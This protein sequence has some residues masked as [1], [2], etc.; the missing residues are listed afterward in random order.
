[1]TQSQTIIF[2][3]S[4]SNQLQSLRRSLRDQRQWRL[5]FAE[6]ADAALAIMRDEPVDIL[7]SETRLDGTK[8]TSLLK[9]AQADHPLTTRLL[10][11]GQALREPA[12]EMVHHAHQFIAKP[13]DKETLVSTL[14]RVIL[15]RNLLNNP[16]MREMV[17]CLGTL[18]SL[19]D[20]YAQLI[21]LLRS[22]TSSVQQIGTLIEQDLA[23][24]AKILQMVNSAFFGLPRRIA[25]PVQAVS[26]L[27]IETVT[28]LTLTAGIF[29]QIDASQVK[30]FGLNTLW[31]HSMQVAGLSRELYMELG[32]TH[33]EA[34]LPFMAGLL[35]DL[36]KLI[37]VATDSDEYR[38]IAEQSKQ[39]ELP[40]YLAE[41]DAL[42]TGHAAI[43]AY[44]M[45]LW[46]LP[47]DAVE[48]VALHHQG[49]PQQL[50]HPQSLVV[51]AANLLIHSQSDKPYQNHYTDDALESLLGSESLDRWKTITQEYLDGETA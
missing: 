21:E 8:G 38:R 18:P 24:S 11:S 19:P 22:E 16:G 48:A 30:A 39:L 42:W 9:Q 43:G 34:D 10:F 7:V 31:N 14:Q 3:D 49:E 28:N 33:Q 5:H 15:L 50:D 4:D 1:M 36:G 37:L 20:T 26:L 29:N 2:V 17:N 35:H 12:Q 47:F 23:M 46:G 40:L 32:Y 45:G 51:Y 25:S 13:C 6:N 27:G 44:L 41:E